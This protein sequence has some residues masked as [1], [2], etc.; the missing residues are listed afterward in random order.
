M[1][2]VKGT[3][4]NEVMD[5]YMQSRGVGRDQITFVDGDSGKKFDGGE[6]AALP[7]AVPKTMVRTNKGDD[8][9]CSC[10]CLA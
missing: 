9:D 3:P 10:T 2:V 1:Q 5:A 7:Y 4:V 8:G 6:P